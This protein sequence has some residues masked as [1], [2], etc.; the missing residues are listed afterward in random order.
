MGWDGEEKKRVEEK[1]RKEKRRELGNHA[2]EQERE[3][4]QAEILIANCSILP[5]H[6]YI[7]TYIQ[8]SP[9]FWKK[10]LCSLER[11]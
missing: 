4:E 6:T 7:H 5:I 2:L 3:Q 11:L 10:S 9:F 8:C 1:G